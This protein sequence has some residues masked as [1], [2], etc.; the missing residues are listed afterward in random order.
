MGGSDAGA[1][2]DFLT[3]YNFAATF[4]EVTRAKG[5]V[6]L[7]TAVRRLTDVPARLYGLRDRGR[8]AAGWWA[9]LCL[10]EADDVGDGPIDWRYDLPGGSPRLYSE[11]RGVRHVIV[12]GAEIVRDGRPLEARAGRVLRSGVDTETVLP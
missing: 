11:P 2:L 9:D 6:P 5:D 10:F 4:L 1:H 7:E 3:T 8:V 12:N